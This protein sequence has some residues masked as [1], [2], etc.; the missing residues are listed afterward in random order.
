MN[1]TITSPRLDLAMKF[2]NETAFNT[3]YNRLSGNAFNFDNY[4]SVQTLRF[5]T[6][7]QLANAVLEMNSAGLEQGQDFTLEDSV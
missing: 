6:Q 1:Y 2:K 7:E 3:G 5:F 4:K